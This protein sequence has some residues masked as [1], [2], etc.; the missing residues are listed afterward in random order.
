MDGL[1]ISK[2]D[3][4]QLWPTLY[5]VHYEPDIYQPFAVSSFC[6]T[7]KPVSNTVYFQEFVEELNDL[8]QN[9]LK[10][11]EKRYNISIKCFICDTPAR[12]FC[13]NIADHIGTYACERCTV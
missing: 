10:I 6:G 4:T 7:S 8:L 1:P 3:E 11:G 13:K 5:Q 9:G 2:S 12:A